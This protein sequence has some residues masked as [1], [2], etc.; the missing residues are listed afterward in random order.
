MKLGINLGVNRRSQVL[1]ESVIPFDATYAHPLAEVSDTFDYPDTATWLA[2]TQAKP[3][4][5]ATD[6]TGLANAS[7]DT[8]ITDG[9]HPT[10]KILHPSFAGAFALYFVGALAQKRWFRGAIKVP[11]NYGVGG[12]ASIGG[13]YIVDDPSVFEFDGGISLEPDGWYVDPD[14]TN[15]LAATL[16]DYKGMKVILTFSAEVVD[17]NT[18]VYDYWVNEQKLARQ[19]QTGSCSGFKA[20]LVNFVPT[21]IGGDYLNITNFET[22]VGDSLTRIPYRGLNGYGP[23]DHIIV[24][25]D[26]TAEVGGV[27]RFVAR[28][29]DV[30][31]ALLPSISPTWT[32]D[33]PDGTVEDGVYTAGSTPGTY[34]VTATVGSVS[35][36][37]TVTV[38]DV[39]TLAHDDIDLFDAAFESDDFAG[40]TDTGDFADAIANRG[41]S[42]GLPAPF[43]LDGVAAPTIETRDGKNV[44]RNYEDGGFFQ[45]SKILP[46]DVTSIT[47]R[48]IRFLSDTYDLEEANEDAYLAMGAAIVNRSAQ[49]LQSMYDPV[50]ETWGIKTDSFTASKS[51]GQAFDPYPMTRA[52]LKGRYVTVVVR[53]DREIGASTARQRMAIDGTVVCDVTNTNM[54]SLDRGSFYDRTHKHGGGTADIV[55][56]YVDTTLYEM[57]NTEACPSYLADLWT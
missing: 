54:T 22:I 25:D 50:T 55:N 6:S 21:G 16:A 35:D 36:S 45:F 12:S 42:G 20:I 57:V 43:T 10:L 24:S 28:G 44:L 19:T 49:G 29:Y 11:A 47:V 37:A 15:A 5:D 39:Q 1:K 8:S 32:T 3:Q 41:V 7:I 18:I 27:L 30:A 2:A 13:A 51:V 31:D 38:V 46:T 33:D 17:A 9:G 40:Y 53:F 23:L 56:N 52:A 26:Q 48:A 34:S 4:Y 14:F